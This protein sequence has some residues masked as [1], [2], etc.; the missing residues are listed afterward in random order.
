MNQPKPNEL[1]LALARERLGELADNE[2]DLRFLSES[3]ALYR[4]KLEQ[5]G[6]DA[7]LKLEA[8]IREMEA[9][10]LK[11]FRDHSPTHFGLEDDDYGR[12]YMA[13]VAAVADDT[14][15]DFKDV[16]LRITDK[17]LREAK[18]AFVSFRVSRT[19]APTCRVLRIDESGTSAAG[20]GR[21][22]DVA[23]RELFRAPQGG[24]A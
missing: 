15:D 23:L 8:K 3:L 19:G 20:E 5:Q 11:V 14:S 13:A 7:R 1:E 9:Q 12:G 21:T 16:A 4:T 2:H 17:R 22:L 10:V 18:V 6:K 24:E